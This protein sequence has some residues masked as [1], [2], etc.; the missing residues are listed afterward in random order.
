IDDMIEHS[1]QCQLAMENTN[2]VPS[3]LQKLQKTKTALN[4]ILQKPNRKTKANQS[5]PSKVPILFT[6]NERAVIRYLL[7]ACDSILN[8]S[9]NQTDENNIGYLKFIMDDIIPHS[10]LF[11]NG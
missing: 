3:T 8:S 2:K 4:E 6:S 10:M 5:T 11:L 1:N 9:T 7:R